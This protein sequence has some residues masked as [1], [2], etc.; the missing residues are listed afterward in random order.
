VCPADAEEFLRYEGVP[1][2]QNLLMPDAH[3]ARGVARGTLALHVCRGCGFVFNPAFDGHLLSYG[4]A[5]DNTQTASPAFDRHVSGLVRELVETQGVR[6]CR[7][8]EVGSG[9]GDFLRQ[10]VSHPGADN[11]GLGF[12]PSHTG[13]PTELDGRLVFH[14]LF[15][16]A[17]SAVSA[18][19][20]VCRHV[21]EHVP[22]PLGLLRSVRAALTESPQARVFFETPCVEW[23]LRNQ[24]G[25][26]FFYEHCSLFTADSLAGAFTAAGFAV[27]EVRHVFGG[28]YLWLEARPAAAAQPP[29]HRPGEVVELARQ[30]AAT[31]RGRLRSWEQ[32]L[33]RLGRSGPVAVWGAG[34]KGSTFCNLADPDGRRVACVVD[35]NPAKQG[36]FVGGTGHPILSPEQAVAAGVAVALVLN[37]NYVSEVE[38]RLASHGSH[39]AVLDMMRAA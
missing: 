12:D 27:T 38:N 39:A 9:K 29:T 23:I 22:D 11:V 35:I 1:V 7:V 8:V 34:A 5:Y 21:I 36:K 37:P 25:W 2:H 20:V 33:D 24:V 18:D 19:V 10:L 28:Q 31:V 15:F 30:Y 13:P 3:S 16:D 32:S 14:R 4:P 6:G 17:D 26:D